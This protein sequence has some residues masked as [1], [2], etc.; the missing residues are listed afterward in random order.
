MHPS[1]GAICDVTWGL[2]VVNSIEGL[3][4]QKVLYISLC[5]YDL[6]VWH[7]SKNQTMEICWYVS[8]GLA[9]NMS[10]LSK[11]IRHQFREIALSIVLINTTHSIDAKICRYATTAVH[12]VC[13][14]ATM[15]FAIWLLHS[16]FVNFLAR[17]T[18]K[19]EHQESHKETARKGWLVAFLVR[20]A[21]RWDHPWR[22]GSRWLWRQWC[23]RC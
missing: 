21:T 11:H 7:L 16:L 1:S 9:V 15:C 4:Q 8:K 13:C 20:T 19:G 17:R 18:S 12:L 5:L 3:L 6:Y 10:V 14:W 2:N 22:P 23:L